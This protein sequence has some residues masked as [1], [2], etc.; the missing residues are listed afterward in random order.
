M[1]ENFDLNDQE[2]DHTLLLETICELKTS[3]VYTKEE[4]RKQSK[5]LLEYEDELKTLRLKYEE[6]KQRLLSQVETTCRREDELQQM[7]T[8]WRCLIENERIERSKMNQ[9]LIEHTKQLEDWKR[10]IQMETEQKY[11]AQIDS[12]MNE[13]SS[14]G[15]FKIL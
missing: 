7:D 9:E 15:L 13:V 14:S 3:N 5:R 11:A 10:N 8:A 1:E 2:H 4:L 12:L 6:S